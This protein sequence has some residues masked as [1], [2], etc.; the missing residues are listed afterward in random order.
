MHTMNAVPK[1]RVKLVG[2]A[3][4]PTRF[5]DFNSLG[6]LDTESRREAVALVRGEPRPDERPPLV[7]IHSQCVTGDVF[8]SLRCDCGPQFQRAM[9]LLASE[10]VALLIYEFDEGRGIG[11]LNKL[12]AYSLQDKGVDT[13]EANLMLGLPVDART[14]E[15]SVAIVEWFHL[16]K[17]RLLTNN[18]E[19]VNALVRNHI[20]VE[21]IPLV[22]EAPLPSQ[23]YLATKKVK[24]GHTM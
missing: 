6:F 24:L 17:V 8:G 16:R 21:R 18:P 11:I 14:Y 10:Q 1:N 5:G 23:G 7:R 13:V 15:T 4:L 20:E 22:V 12:R 3:K 2:H 9:E 19:K